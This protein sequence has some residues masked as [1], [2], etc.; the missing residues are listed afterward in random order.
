MIKKFSLD[1]ISDYT[2]EKELREAGFLGGSRPAIY[3][4]LNRPDVKIV[5]IG[6]RKYI[7]KSAL[8]EFFEKNAMA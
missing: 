5:M 3:A 4:F 8:M 2:Y 7:A 1:N 6:R